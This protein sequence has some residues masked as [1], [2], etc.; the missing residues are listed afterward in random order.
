MRKLIG[1]TDAKSVKLLTFRVKMDNIFPLNLC[2]TTY[3]V[4]KRKVEVC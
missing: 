2:P 1:K 3:V 4:T